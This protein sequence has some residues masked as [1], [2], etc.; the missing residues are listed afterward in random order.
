[1]NQIGTSYFHVLSFFYL[2]ND[3]NNNN[4]NNN[5]S[6]NNPINSN[7]SNNGL[8][9]VNT[10]GGGIRRVTEGL[11]TGPNLNAVADFHSH[12]NLDADSESGSLGTSLLYSSEARVTGTLQ[13]SCRIPKYFTAFCCSFYYYYYY[14]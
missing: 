5:N 7:N 8:V 1:M 6:N 9:S 13:E 3:N 2:N 14:I 11:E 12:F 4:N 10:L